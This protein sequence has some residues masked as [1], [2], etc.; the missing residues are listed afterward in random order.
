VNKLQLLPRVS[1]SVVGEDFADLAEEQSHSL[2][3]RED[4]ADLACGAS[5]DGVACLQVDA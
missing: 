5:C 4:V 2:F 1:L 3:V